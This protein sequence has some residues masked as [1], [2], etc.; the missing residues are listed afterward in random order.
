M[1]IPVNTA[2]SGL[3]IFLRFNGVLTDPLSIS[4]K[5]FEPANTAV[6]SSA[7]YRRSV[8]HYDARNSII[9][10][11]YDI[12]KSWLITWQFKS[13][14]G[15]TST[16]SENFAVTDSL[17]PSFSN[18][19]NLVEQIKLDLGLT[20]EYTQ[21]QY[22]IFIVKALNRINRKLAYTGTVRELR[23]DDTTGTIIPTPNSTM[24]DIILLQI[25]CLMV[26]Q[27]RKAA[28]SK[29]IRVRDGDSQID[30]T[31]GFGGHDSVVKDICGELDDAIA[32]ALWGDDA[33][34]DS[35]EIIWYGNSRIYADMDH[36]GDGSGETKDYSSPFDSFQ[37]YFPR[38]D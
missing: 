17:L 29:G 16:A 37:G 20:N 14:A 34:I 32:D 22:E 21:S 7:G 6:A 10:S 36:D 18:V 5:I 31:A 4:Y 35:A 30:T 12:T 24:L 27:S 25:E 26:K 3:D 8:G 11:G 1:L 33:V 2:P 38:R 15:I 19:D 13:P 9:P 28:V 23:F